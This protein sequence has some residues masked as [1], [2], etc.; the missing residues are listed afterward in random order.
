MEE[1]G[2]SPALDTDSGVRVTD[3][4]AGLADGYPFPILLL[5]LCF[6]CPQRRLSLLPLP[7][8]LLVGS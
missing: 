3:R 6:F 7:P 1:G 4:A 2:R 8:L 5:L